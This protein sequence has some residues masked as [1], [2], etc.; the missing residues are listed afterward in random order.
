MGGDG[1][2]A[3]EDGGVVGGQIGFKR[4]VVEMIAGNELSAVSELLKGRDSGIG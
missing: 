4:G 2:L 1:Q 3:G